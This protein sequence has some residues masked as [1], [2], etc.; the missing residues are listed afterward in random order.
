MKIEIECLGELCE[1]C[2][3]LKLV[4]RRDPKNDYLIVG[5]SCENLGHCRYIVNEYLREI[6]KSTKG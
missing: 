2:A 5:W 1:R 6:R 3:N 4:E